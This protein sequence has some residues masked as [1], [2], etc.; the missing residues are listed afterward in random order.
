MLLNKLSNHIPAKLPAYAVLRL[1]HFQRVGKKYHPARMIVNVLGINLIPIVVLLFFLALMGDYRQYLISQELELLHTKTKLYS[2]QLQEGNK[3]N[4]KNFLANNNETIFVFSAEGERL[5]DRNL[6]I[7]DGYM[8]TQRSNTERDKDASWANRFLNNLVLVVLSNGSI[9]HNVPVY[10][11]VDWGDHT[12]IPGVSESLEGETTLSVW[13]GTKDTLF[14]SSSFPVLGIDDKPMSLTIIY[15]PDRLM[16]NILNLQEDIFR[17]FLSIFILSIAF[18]LYL[19]GT[20]THPLRR[21]AM[22]V[23]DI[24]SNTSISGQTIPDMSHRGDEIGELS[25]TLNSMVEALWQRMDTIESFAADVSHELKNPITSLKSALETLQKVKDKKDANQLMKILEHDIDRLD[26]L[27]TDISKSTRLDVELSQ[28]LFADVDV[29]VLV[30]TVIDRYAHQGVNID[31]DVLGDVGEYLVKGHEDK[32]VQVLTNLID[33]AY[34][35]SPDYIG[36]T[37]Q[38]YR[39]DKKEYVMICVEDKGIGLSENKLGTIFERFYSDRP[40]KEGIVHHSG[41]GLSIVRQIIN[42]HNGIITAKNVEGSDKKISGA[43]F[44]VI[45]PKA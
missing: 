9:S 2:H 13:A 39:N 24:R 23:E 5:H 12:S 34:S 26:R 31:F 29:R 8:S 45:L 27:I 42:A 19:V 7:F 37:I 3:E 25:V 15:T 32:L 18:S 33:N 41:L 21:L 14:F 1:Q 16:K 6:E 43:I 11:A 44:E 22:A 30:S 28:G 40:K 4:F 20:I 17:I 35:F 36:V 10:P 38:E